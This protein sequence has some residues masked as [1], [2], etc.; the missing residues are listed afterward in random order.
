[1]SEIV[2]LGCG[3]RKTAGALGVDIF[4]Y[5]GVDVVADLDKPGWPLEDGRFDRVIASHVIEHVQ[6]VIMFLA[7]IHRI[8]RPDAEVVLTTP[9]FSSRNSYADATHLRHLAIPWYETFVTGGYLSER[10]GTFELVHSRVK[11]GKSAR[12]II[13]K[14]MIRLFGQEVWEK[15]YAFQ[16]PATD[17]ETVLRV[18]K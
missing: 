8:A 10:S 6:D 3:P 7:E 16:Y 12:T 11:F 13:P 14:V 9:H 18:K 2:D 15:Q 4:P 17:L 5:P 1:M